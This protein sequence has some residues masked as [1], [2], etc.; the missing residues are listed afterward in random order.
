MVSKLEEYG[1]VPGKDNRMWKAAMVRKS[2]VPT[3]NQKNPSMS[4]PQIMRRNMV[5]QEVGEI[6][7][8][9]FIQGFMGYVFQ[10]LS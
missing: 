2:K 4:R 5:Q 3:R 8:H 7:K 10:Y 9:Q 6:S 1:S